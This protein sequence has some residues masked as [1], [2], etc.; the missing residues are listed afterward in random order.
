MIH[1]TLS[2]EEK[3]VWLFSL[4]V[5][6]FCLSL[7]RGTFGSRT[8]GCTIWQYSPTVDLTD[9]NWWTTNEPIRERASTVFVP[10]STNDADITVNTRRSKQSCY[11]SSSS[12][13][14]GP[15]VLAVLY[16]YSKPAFVNQSDHYYLNKRQW[17]LRNLPLPLVSDSDTHSQSMKQRQTDNERERDKIH[18]QDTAW[19]CTISRERRRRRRTWRETFALRLMTKVHDYMIVV[20]WM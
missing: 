6:R 9:G 14:S 4:H 8:F 19:Y 12:S 13:S 2:L 15:S 5:I 20:R 3:H 17:S 11:T 7:P 1:D 18:H 10:S 16:S